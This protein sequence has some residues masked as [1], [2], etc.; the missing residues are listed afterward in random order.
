MVPEAVLELERAV[1]LCPGFA[2]LRTK[3]ATLYR[4]TNQS[5]RAKEQLEAARDANPNYGQARLLLGVMHLSAG[6]YEAAIREFDAV[7][8][9]DGEHKSALMYRKLAEAQRARSEHPGT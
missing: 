4:D 6:E 9:R 2:D 1:A 7:L 8:L 3:L 5:D